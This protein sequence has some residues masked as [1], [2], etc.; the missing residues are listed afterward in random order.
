MGLRTFHG[1]QD[2][3]SEYCEQFRTNHRESLLERLSFTLHLRCVAKIHC[4]PQTHWPCACGGGACSGVDHC[5]SEGSFVS[6]SWLVGV[7]N[8]HE[9][10]PLGM[11]PKQYSDLCVSM[12]AKL[13]R[14][15][16]PSSRL[17]YFSFVWCARCVK[18][19]RVSFATVL[20]VMR[21]DP[22]RTTG[23]SVK[24][25]AMALM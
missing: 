8:A 16:Q 24:R 14:E 6:V 22:L 23:S 7:V 15:L 11:N 21:F 12:L 13:E 17:H 18:R 2:T 19:L 4:R 25:S 10:V 3:L 9:Y 20:G 1:A 5:F